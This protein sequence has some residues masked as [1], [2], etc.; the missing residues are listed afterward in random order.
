MSSTTRPSSSERELMPLAAAGSPLDDPAELT[1]NFDFAYNNEQFSDTVLILE[2]E[3]SESDTAQVGED[4]EKSA[5]KGKDD[6]E[7]EQQSKKM[8]MDSGAASL[9]RPSSSNTNNDPSDGVMARLN[10]CK[11]VLCCKSLFFKT[12][13]TNGMKETNQKT[14]S[15]KMLL[16]DKDTF[17]SLIKY[18]YTG[19][20]PTE[21]DLLKMVTLADKYSVP[22][23]VEEAAR[24][25]SRGTYTVE[26]CCKFLDLPEKIAPNS[27]LV[28]LIEVASA[29]IVKEFEDFDKM[30][31]H[32]S[33][34]G[35]SARGVVEVLKS[36]NLKVSSE[37]TVYQAVRT[38]VVRD[39]A[40]EHYIPLLIPYIRWPMMTRN[41]LLDVVKDDVLFKHNALQF[42]HYVAQAMEHHMAG[43]ERTKVIPVVSDKS[44]VT[45]RTGYQ[46]LLKAELL[47]DLKPVSAMLRDGSTRKSP[48]QY[49]AGY[50]IWL[51][52]EKKAEELGLF[53]CGEPLS[54]TTPIQTTK[55]FFAKFQCEFMMRNKTT[56][57]YNQKAHFHPFNLAFDSVHNGRCG[58]GYGQYVTGAEL[59]N[60]QFDFL[61]DDTLYFK[62]VATM[63]P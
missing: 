58:K 42:A 20:F 5:Q 61:V 38:W 46:T 12:L 27:A 43:E 37:N 22:C 11:L 36:N 56:G 50:K 6:S 28:K 19:R 35:L 48:V 32:D 23:A 4:E 59:G 53:F 47:W 29:S 21:I 54:V 63:D 13:F 15:I 14:V 55:K 2:E 1:F 3:F 30:W 17:I 31:S 57:E 44:L 24:L 62:A 34:L 7:G 41:F 51:K 49:L 60:A 33:F 45:T 9:N 25:L 16:E 39:T 8:K 26:E 18:L 52:V 10:V 40:R